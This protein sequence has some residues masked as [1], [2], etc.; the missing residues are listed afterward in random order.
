M[1]KDTLLGLY[2]QYTFTVLSFYRVPIWRSTTS[3]F[4]LMGLFH[5]LSIVILF[6]MSGKYFLLLNDD[7]VQFFARLIYCCNHILFCILYLVKFRSKVSDCVRSITFMY[8][9][10]ILDI[11]TP[12]QNCFYVV[13]NQ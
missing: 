8:T 9:L 11:N 3:A 12:S 2:A 13:N 5:S 6:P 4:C 1:N 10:L 7:V